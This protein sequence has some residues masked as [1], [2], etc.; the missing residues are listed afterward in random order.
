VDRPL[1]IDESDQSKILFS[2]SEGQ[3]AGESVVQCLNSARYSII[4]AAVLVKD[5]LD[6]F[7][8]D[9]NALDGFVHTLVAGGVVAEGDARLGENA[10][11]LSAY[12]KVGEHS[13][14][15]LDLLQYFDPSLYVY[16]D[17][18]RLFE[19][20]SRDKRALERR[21]KAMA[22]LGVSRESLQQEIRNLKSGKRAKPTPSPVKEA[23]L[24]DSP[25]QQ[26]ETPTKEFGLVVAT[27]TK[28]DIQLLA[29]DLA[30]PDVGTPECMRVHEWTSSKAVLFVTSRT[31]DLPIV[32]QRLLPYCGFSRAS[33]IFLLDNPEEHDITQCRVMTVASRGDYPL[34]ADKLSEGI[35]NGLTPFAIAADLATEDDGRLHLFADRTFLGWTSIVGADNWSVGGAS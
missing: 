30:Y 25:R 4:E 12:R 23:G 15:L 21:L 27:P 7:R 14:L 10:S 1:P 33:H 24:P 31:I 28:S 26:I 32:V 17:V 2:K 35:A 13:S 20:L 19:A 18:V 6:R 3:A 8:Q 29:R 22:Q 9:R 11:K 16:Y 5:A 34:E